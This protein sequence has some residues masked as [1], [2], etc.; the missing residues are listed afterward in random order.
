MRCHKAAGSVPSRAV[1][2]PDGPPRVAAAHV[3]APRLFRSQELTRTHLRSNCHR[4]R[5][6]PCHCE[7]PFPCHCERPF[8]CHCERSVAISSANEKSSRRRDRRVASLL[9]MTHWVRART[10]GL[11][12]VKLSFRLSPESL[13]L[14]RPVHPGNITSPMAR[15]W[16]AP[17]L[18]VACL[19]GPRSFVTISAHERYGSRTSVLCHRRAAVSL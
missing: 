9:A 2:I 11:S 18:S 13:N 10:P 19:F 16:K 14:K 15:L 3:A 17:V 8:P 5:P 12:K 4:E 7:R 1:T 6:F